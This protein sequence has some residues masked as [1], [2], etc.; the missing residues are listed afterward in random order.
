MTQSC[1]HI[2]LWHLS[3]LFL[4][5]LI[6]KL[7]EA[8]SIL[9]RPEYLPSYIFMCPKEKEELV[10]TA[11]LAYIEWG[12]TQ[13]FNET[14]SCQIRRPWYNI[15]GPSL[16]HLSF[17]RR[18]ASTTA[19]TFYTREGCYA[20]DRFVNI[21]VPID[22]QVPLCYYLNSTLFQLVVNINGRSSLGYG[23]LEVQA[24]DLKNLPCL[25]TI[26]LLRGG[27]HRPNRP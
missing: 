8:K 25:Y 13:R 5:P 19:K 9:I 7:E 21:Y 26:H 1:C 22:M 20:L 11:A 27:G 18:T 12:E 14:R 3:H 17:P 16:P 24:A 10:G 15:R 4:K 6:T 23:A 2:T